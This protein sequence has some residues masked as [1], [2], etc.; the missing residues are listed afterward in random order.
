MNADVELPVGVSMGELCL[1]FSKLELGAQ[2]SDLWATA[3]SIGDANLVSVAEGMRPPFS[4]P[5]HLIPL[6][7]W[8]QVSMFRAHSPNLLSQ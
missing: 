7:C 1:A 5:I 2:N 4:D 8:P 6:Q 3:E